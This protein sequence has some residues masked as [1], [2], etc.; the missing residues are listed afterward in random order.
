MR[1]GGFDDVGEGLVGRLWK[2]KAKK[3]RVRSQDSV[4]KILINDPEKVREQRSGKGEK[5]KREKK[6]K[7]NLPQT[8]SPES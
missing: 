7:S 2:G 3:R 5:G 1:K 8:S 4:G 6:K